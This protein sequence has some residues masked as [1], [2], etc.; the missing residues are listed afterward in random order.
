MIP[1]FEN[2]THDLTD[3]ELMEVLPVMIKSLETKVG[4]D[5]QIPASAMVNKLELAP[6]NIKTTPPRIRKMIRHIRIMGLVP[7]LIGGGQGYYIATTKEEMIK[8]IDSLQIRIDSIQYTCDAINFQ[9]KSKFGLHG[10][11]T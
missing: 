6:W 2:Y 11:K 8:Y 7:C 5:K 3:R 9:Y 10:K 4:K 1:G